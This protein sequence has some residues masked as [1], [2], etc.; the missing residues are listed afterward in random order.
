MSSTCEHKDVVCEF[1]RN[2]FTEK[3]QV[4]QYSMPSNKKAFEKKLQDAMKIEYRKGAN[5]EMILDEK[6]REKVNAWIDS[7]VACLHESRSK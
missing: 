3:Y 5:G 2:Y 4:A 6:G 1:L 7:I